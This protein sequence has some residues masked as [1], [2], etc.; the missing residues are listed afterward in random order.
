MS[1]YRTL[2]TCPLCKRHVWV[3]KKGRFEQ[4]LT[5]KMGGLKLSELHS[6]PAMTTTDIARLTQEAAARRTCHK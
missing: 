4:H 3:S 1:K 6:I 5:C 2:Q